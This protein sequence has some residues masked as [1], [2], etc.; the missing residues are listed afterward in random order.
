M[1]TIVVKSGSVKISVTNTLKAVNGNKA[2]SN[3]FKGL[4]RKYSLM[5][6][7]RGSR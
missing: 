6:R 2:R 3:R 7:D 5:L 1:S 4:K